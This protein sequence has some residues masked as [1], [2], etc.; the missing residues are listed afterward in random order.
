MLVQTLYVMAGKPSVSG[1]KSRFTDVKAGAWYYDALLWGEKNSIC[2]GYP[3]V[4]SPTFGIGKCLQRQ[5]MAFMLMRYSEYMKY[6]RAIDFG[7]T[8]DY[9]DYYDI[10]YYAWEAL[11]WAVTWNIMEGKGAPGSPKSQQRIDP[12]GKVTRDELIK[13][14]KNMLEINN[15]TK[16]S[17]PIP[18]YVAP[19]KDESRDKDDISS[20]NQI[21]VKEF[22]KL[23]KNGQDNQDA[24]GTTFSILKAK[25]TSKSKKSVKLSWE[26]VPGANKYIIYGNKCGKKLKN[27]KIATVT[28]NTYTVK[29]LK[30]GTH[31]KYT[32]V[33]VRGDNVLAASKTIHV[34]TSGGKTGNYTKVKLSKSKLKLEAGKSKK[35]KATLKSGKKKVKI[36]RKLAWESDNIAVATVKNGKIKAVGKGTCYVYAYAQNGVYAKIKVTVK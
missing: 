31:Y 28:G 6:E 18:A 15:V 29:K 23:I 8:D 7:R 25:G 21:K 36:H 1:L 10:D 30:K 26:N 16:T 11:T 33:A 9:I 35:I 5:D 20:E 4:S 2:M 13:T 14:I 19:Q 24:K 32:V 12:H 3:Y 22:E 27:K 17:I 34:I